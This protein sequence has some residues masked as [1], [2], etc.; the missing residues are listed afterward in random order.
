M[1]NTTLCGARNT[2]YTL[3]SCISH[4]QKLSAFHIY[5]KKQ[6]VTLA[7]TRIQRCHSLCYNSRRAFSTGSHQCQIELYATLQ[8]KHHI[9][10]TKG[11]HIVDIFFNYMLTAVVSVSL[12]QLLLREEVPHASYLANINFI[13]R[14]C[15][16]VF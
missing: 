9:K 16:R 10:P 5:R 14:D 4:K 12:I 8:K 7:R 11:F 15:D 13:K 6:P 1:E 3:C 2:V